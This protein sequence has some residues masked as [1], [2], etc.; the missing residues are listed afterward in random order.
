MSK[1][2]S[3]KLTMRNEKRAGSNVFVWGL[4]GF[5]RGSI[6]FYYRFLQS[7]N[8]LNSLWGKEINDFSTIMKKN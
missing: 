4:V 3:E 6:S 2:Q 1:E 7:R 5:Q 8:F